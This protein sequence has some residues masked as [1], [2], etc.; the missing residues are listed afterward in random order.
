MA[1]HGY[2][3]TTN[4]L[5][6]ITATD[7]RAER[8]AGLPIASTSSPEPAT[9]A[10]RRGEAVLAIIARPPDTERMTIAVLA[11]YNVAAVGVAFAG[12]VVER[13][14]PKVGIGLMLVAALALLNLFVGG[15]ILFVPLIFA[16]YGLV[17]GPPALAIWYI[18]RT[19][20]RRRASDRAPATLPPEP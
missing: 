10:A 17:L 1:R 11:L 13:R 15:A 16:L 19:F 12:L 2:R 14:H 9:L 20:R 8:I 5:G 18:V 6:S 3:G 4:K 7:R